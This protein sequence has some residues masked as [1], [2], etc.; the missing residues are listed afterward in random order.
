MSNN[1]YVKDDEINKSKSS[2]AIYANEDIKYEGKARKVE[3][4]DVALALQRNIHLMDALAYEILN[5][6][7]SFKYSSSRQI[8]EYLNII[9]KI[10][11]TQEKV[12][13][14]L[15]KLNKLSI[16]SRYGFYNLESEKE[17]GMKAYCLE[18]NGKVLLKGKGYPC[19]W[20]YTDIINDI[21]TIKSYLA[22]NQFVIKLYKESNKIQEVNLNP[23][24][25]SNG[26]I[27]KLEGG[28]GRVLIP[29]RT[30][31]NYQREIIEAVSKLI[32]SPEYL[33]LLNK[34]IIILTEEVKHTVVVCNTLMQH[35]LYLDNMYLFKI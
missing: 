25:I 32:K 34:K 5:A 24:S 29:I 4:K 18:N 8:T 12:C 6:I 20:K 14:K 21:S 10:D 15:D 26:C 19:E 16:I 27:Y 3:M 30:N 23:F 2:Y 1:L 28:I 13:K 11:V 9:K 17:V 33:S 31:Q 22:R 7:Y 35:S